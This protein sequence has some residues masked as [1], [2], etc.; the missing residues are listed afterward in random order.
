[1]RIAIFSDIHGNPYAAR[2]VLAAITERGNFDAVV[3]ACQRQ[4]WTWINEAVID[5]YSRLFSMGF[6]RSIEGYQDAQLVSGLWGLKVGT[7]FGVMS[8]FHQADRAGAIL[9]GALV[10][11]LMAG[12]ENELSFSETYFSNNLLSI[13]LLSFSGN[14]FCNIF[15]INIVSFVS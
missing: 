1:M 6:A 5:I 4:G 7:T 3:R 8:M 11:E 15:L 14:P 9:F 13:I 2:A 10:E 12:D